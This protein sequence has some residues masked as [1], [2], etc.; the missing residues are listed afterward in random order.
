MIIILFFFIFFRTHSYSNLK[1]RGCVGRHLSWFNSWFGYNNY[2]KTGY[3]SNKNW[4]RKISLIVLLLDLSSRR[5]MAGVPDFRSHSGNLSSHSRFFNSLNLFKPPNSSNI[6]NFP[7]RGLVIALTESFSWFAPAI[8][9]RLWWTYKHYYCTSTFPK[10]LT[11]RVSH[12]WHFHSCGNSFIQ[13][14][15]NHKNGYHGRQLK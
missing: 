5:E 2:Y 7:M 11:M 4:I 14:N 3:K 13:S 6:R 8:L 1:R 15:N 10:T 9:E 12:Q